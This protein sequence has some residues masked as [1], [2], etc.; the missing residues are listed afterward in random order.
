M[1]LSGPFGGAN[2]YVNLLYFYKIYRRKR[3]VTR[4][5]IFL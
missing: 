3:N 1:T 5:L 2:Q 4:D